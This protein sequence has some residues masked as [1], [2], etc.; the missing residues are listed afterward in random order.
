MFDMSV[1][2]DSSTELGFD[3]RSKV[4]FLLEQKDPKN[5]G[6][7]QEFS[8]CIVGWHWKENYLLMDVD[9][10]KVDSFLGF[11]HSKD[12]VLVIEKY[13]NVDWTSMGVGSQN[14]G[15]FWFPCYLSL[16]HDS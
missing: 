4:D 12:I 3:L 5:I 9:S 2:L 16:N 11:Y 8:H 1:E 7:S 13:S 6:Y 14:I 15:F 10:N